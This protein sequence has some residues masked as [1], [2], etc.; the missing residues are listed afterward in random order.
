MVRSEK[1]SLNCFVF[2]R[3]AKYLILYLFLADSPRISIPISVVRTIPEHI[4]WCSAEG[5][6]PI[7]MS[8][9][10]GSA[11]VDRGIGIVAT[12]IHE[13]GNYTC[14]AFNGA[15]SDSRNITVTFIGEDFFTQFCCVAYLVV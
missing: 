13:E 10:K 3:I 5:T 9:L 4:F 11:L 6:P 8:L 14:Q 1:T 15:G 2:T 12:R 7:R